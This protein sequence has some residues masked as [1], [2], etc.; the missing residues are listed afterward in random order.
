MT[1]AFAHPRNRYI[2]IYYREN[3]QVEQVEQANPKTYRKCKN[4]TKHG[5]ES[6]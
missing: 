2:Y 3:T 5:R 6:F 4:G 1:C